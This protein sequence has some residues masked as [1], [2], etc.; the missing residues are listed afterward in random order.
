MYW[1]DFFSTN[2]VWVSIANYPLSYIEAISVAAGL[3]AVWLSARANIWTWPIGIVN[4]VSAFWVFYQVHLYADMFLQIY[5]LIMTFIGWYNWLRKEQQTDKGI[6][7]L[8]NS[9]RA[10]LLLAIILGTWVW[11]QVMLHLHEWLPVWFPQKVAFAYTDSWIAV[12]SVAAMVLMAQKKVENWWLWIAIDVVATIVYYSK[13]I[14]FF[15]L[16]YFV[17]LILASYGLWHWEQQKKK[18]QFQ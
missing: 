11:A 3:A 6:S 1:I 18:T 2:N 7:I 8:S 10:M 12:G 17:F 15:A 4:I 16:E 5:F 9:Q 13:G 14:R